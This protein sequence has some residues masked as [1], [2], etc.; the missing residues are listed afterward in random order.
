MSIDNDY[1]VILERIKHIQD[2]VIEIKESQKFGE[3][4]A[5]NFE[6]HY[7]KDHA[8]VVQQAE[9]AHKRLNGHEDKIGSLENDLGALIKAMQ[10]LV[11]TNRF[12]RWVGGIVGAALL[13][14]IIAVIT[15]Q[16]Q[17]MFR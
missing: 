6:R 12:L 3:E 8:V 15:G 1:G 17:L 14:L 16:V 7:I 5:Q 4:R 11:S 10:P 2:D 9:A 13:A